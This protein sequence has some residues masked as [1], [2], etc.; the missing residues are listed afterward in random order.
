MGIRSFIKRTVKEAISTGPVPAPPKP[1]QRGPLPVDKD[2]LGFQ[3]V[4]HAGDLAEGAGR[5]VV[6]DDHGIALFLVGGRY[7]AVD[8]ACT[9]EDAPLGEGEME[10]MIVIC[11]YHDWKYDV[12]TG[13]CLT[14]PARPVGCFATQ[15]RDGMV[16]V[17]PRTSEGTTERGGD[18]NDGLKV[19][20]PI[21]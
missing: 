10:G 21:R 12:S 5:T 7:F 9:H 15:I 14:D 2:A 11:P 4:L 3:A 18:H 19:T 13:A 20:D 17:G 1:V 8:D 16:W 6:V